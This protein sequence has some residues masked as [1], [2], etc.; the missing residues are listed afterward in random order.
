[1]VIN[2]AMREAIMRNKMKIRRSM[3]WAFCESLRTKCTKRAKSLKSS[4]LAKIL[5]PNTSRAPKGKER[6]K[7]A[8]LS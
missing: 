4:S 8:L 5:V 3:V 7:M 1:M 2:V 6:P